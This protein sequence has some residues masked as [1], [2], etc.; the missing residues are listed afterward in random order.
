MARH[1]T[2]SFENPEYFYHFVMNLQIQIRHVFVIYYAPLIILQFKVIQNL[3][4]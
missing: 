1:H 4:K 2:P 3:G